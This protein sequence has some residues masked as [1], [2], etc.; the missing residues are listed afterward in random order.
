M[1]NI[2]LKSHPLYN[3]YSF[4]NIFSQIYS[5]YKKYFKP[6]FLFSFITSLITVIYLNTL[7]DVAAFQL[8]EEP[9]E[10]AEILSGE[11]VPILGLSVLSLF[12]MIVLCHYII[13]KPIEESTTFVSSMGKSGALLVPFTIAT[14][15]YFFAFS[16]AFIL[17]ILVFVVGAILTTAYML[18]I[19]LIF[20]QV[21]L[22]EGPSIGNA[23][24]RSFKL[25]HK[26]IYEKIG[27]TIF[28]TIAFAG[29]SSILS[30]IVSLPFAGKYLFEVLE[31]SEDVVEASYLSNPIYLILSALVTSLFRPIFPIF[32]VMLYMDGLAKENASTQNNIIIDSQEDYTTD[33]SNDDDIVNDNDFIID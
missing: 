11:I 27:W 18:I 15:L 24:N 20:I 31:S 6:L 10:L 2:N 29:L 17:G 33:N 26:G 28:V 5:F 22:V 25:A 3:T 19:G 32:G 30:G 8:A 13:Y 23:I 9:E 4:D 1:E 21:L 16:L 12:F 7:V 14:I